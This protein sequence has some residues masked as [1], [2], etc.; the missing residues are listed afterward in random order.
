MVVAGQE[1]AVHKV[2]VVLHTRRGSSIFTEL[3]TSRRAIEGVHLLS[4]V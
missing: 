1:Y 4:R 3:K 2:V